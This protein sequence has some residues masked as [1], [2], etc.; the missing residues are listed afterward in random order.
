[1]IGNAV[2]VRHGPFCFRSR[3]PL[4]TAYTIEACTDLH[5]WT[6]IS[7]NVSSGEELEY[8][9]SEAFKFS[10]RFY[11]LVVEGV[12]PSNVIGYAS[13]TLPPRFSLIANPLEAPS[14]TV[15]EMFK[16][17]PDG[18]A[19]HKFD[20]MFFRF[21]ENTVKFGKWTN[22]SETLVPGEGALFFNP[23]EDYKM[24][25]FVGQVREGHL[26]MPIP[27]GFSVRSSFLPQPGSV[28]ELGFPISDGDVVHLFDRDSQAYVAYAHEGGKWGGSAPVIGVGESFWVAK[29]E[30]ANWKPKSFL[31]V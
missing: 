9:D 30:A 22:P 1:M 29:T 2:R 10:Y 5:T 23:T 26:S 31:N 18:T 19:L 8:V 21:M 14:S 15:G 12:R 11:R 13:I 16:G 3:L 24:L 7:Q 17:W 20:T 6:P 4:E 28:Q 27:S 25:S